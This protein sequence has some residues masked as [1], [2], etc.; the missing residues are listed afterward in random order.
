MKEISWVMFFLKEL[1]IQ[2]TEM[3][4]CSNHCFQRTDGVVSAEVWEGT[5]NT[6]N[7]V[8]ELLPETGQTKSV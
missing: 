3:I 7:L 8:S 4:V 6:P 2:L 1:C 5:L